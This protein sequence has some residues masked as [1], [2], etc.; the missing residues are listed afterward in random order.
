MS[1]RFFLHGLAQQ[2]RLQKKR[3]WHKGSLGDEDDVRTSNTRL[4]Q[5]QHTIPHS[6]MNNILRNVIECC[7]NT[8]QGA[9][10]TGKQTIR[11]CSVG[12]YSAIPYIQNMHVEWKTV[13]GNPQVTRK[14][15]E[16]AKMCCACNTSLK[17]VLRT[18]VTTSHVTCIDIIV[19]LV[20]CNVACTSVTTLEE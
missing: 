3:N 2:R 12:Q 20:V 17:L 9:Q 1:T 16:F 11:T 15:K 18:L 14:L 19:G 8:H 4:A 7:N 5:T 6:V 13:T 10:I